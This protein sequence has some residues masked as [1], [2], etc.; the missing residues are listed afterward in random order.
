MQVNREVSIARVLHLRTRVLHIYIHVFVAKFCV[1]SVMTCD[2]GVLRMQRLAHARQTCG[3]HRRAATDLRLLH[4][5]LFLYNPIAI[6]RSFT[7]VTFHCVLSA[8]YSTVSLY[9]TQL[10]RIASLV[11]ATPIRFHF[12]LRFRFT[13][14]LISSSPRHRSSIQSTRLQSS[15]RS[16]RQEQ[17]ADSI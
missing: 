15:D 5:S 1:F 3:R 6:S 10:H 14:R 2:R 8:F 16:S 9:S 7:F 4:L 13:F 11:F 17:S 12:V